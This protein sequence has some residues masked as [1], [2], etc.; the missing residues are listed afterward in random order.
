MIVPTGEGPVFPLWEGFLSLYRGILDWGT[1]LWDQM[2]GVPTG[3]TLG[4]GEGV[5]AEF[6]FHL[7]ARRSDPAPRAATPLGPLWPGA[8]G[9]LPLPAIR[10]KSRIIRADSMRGSFP[11][12]GNGCL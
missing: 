2:K 4:G 5:S 1:L 3:K 10:W 8:P 6:V 11:W 12:E 7:R 9:R